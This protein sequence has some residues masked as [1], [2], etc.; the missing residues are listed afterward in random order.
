M[1]VL[2]S[3]LQFHQPHHLILLEHLVPLKELFFINLPTQCYLVG[4]I[5]FRLMMEVTSVIHYILKVV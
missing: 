3:Y 4:L 5:L 2:S 1:L